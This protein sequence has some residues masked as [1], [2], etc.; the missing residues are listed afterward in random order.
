MDYAIFAFLITLGLFLGMLL[1]LDLGR[2]IGIRRRAQDPDGATAGTGAVD[3]AVFALLGL[4]IAFTFSGAASRFDTRRNLIVEEANDIGTAYLRINLLP[5]SAQPE[6][7]ESVRRYV[8][9]R[10]EAYRKL[11]DVEAAKVELAKAAQLQNE[12]WNQA[13]AA[14]RLEGAQPAATMLLL[15]ALNQ[16]FDITTTRTMATQMHPPKIIFAMLFVLALASSLLAGYGMAG[17]K[18]R[19]W[20]H[21]GGFALIMAFAIYVILDLEY[22]RIGLIR[23]DAF[24]QVIMEVRA[25]MK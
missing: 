25:G 10:L 9:A 8:D 19:N 17:G 14:G 22:P 11:P 21:M 3:G 15:P 18:S 12:I 4:L 2:R 7:R 20:I 6:L 23:V 13:I 5:A 24:D 16:M 1:L